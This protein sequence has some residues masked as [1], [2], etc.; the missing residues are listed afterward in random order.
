[1]PMDL[2]PYKPGSP[3]KPQKISIQPTYN[4]DRT[5]S[6]IS[7]TDYKHSSQNIVLHTSEFIIKLLQHSLVVEAK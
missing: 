1:M 7:I 6:S 3:M 2:N 4:Q 5:W